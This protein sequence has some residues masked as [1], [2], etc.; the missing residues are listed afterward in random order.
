MPMENIKWFYPL[1]KL[2]EWFEKEPD[3]KIVFMVH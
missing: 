3:N 2:V 1:T